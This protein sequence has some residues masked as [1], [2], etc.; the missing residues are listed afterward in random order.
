[1]RLDAGGA[2]L[3]C[4]KLFLSSL[5]LQ[6]KIVIFNQGCLSQKERPTIHIFFY[7]LSSYELSGYF[8]WFVVSN[9]ISDILSHPATSRFRIKIP[10]NT[11]VH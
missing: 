7:L 3:P 4:T 10:E 8:P 9:I 11:P 5:S 6:Y 1:M 2:R